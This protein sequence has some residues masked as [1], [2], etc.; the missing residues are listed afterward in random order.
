VQI[1]QN[2]TQAIKPLRSRW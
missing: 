1:K 2:V